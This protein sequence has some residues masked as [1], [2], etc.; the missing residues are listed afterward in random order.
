MVFDKE[1]LLAI[2]DMTK[3]CRA[4]AG[5]LVGSRQQAVDRGL[6]SVEQ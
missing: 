1:K 3:G 4:D 5:T 2:Y 6:F